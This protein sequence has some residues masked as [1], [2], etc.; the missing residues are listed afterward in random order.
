MTFNRGFSLIEVLV[1]I[2]VVA[3]SGIGTLKL[4]GYMEVEKANAAMFIEAKVIAESQVALIQTVNTTGSMCAGKTFEN[5]NDCVNQQEDSPF[6]VTVTSAKSLTHEKVAG[7]VETYGKVYKVTVAWTDRNNEGK[8]LVIPV[9]VS[10]YT[11]L[12]E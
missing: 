10:K 12:L 5:I 6:A 7:V 8:A 4:Y 9:S 11:N 1:S 2:V 3:L